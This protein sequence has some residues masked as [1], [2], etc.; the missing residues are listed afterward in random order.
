MAIEVRSMHPDVEKYAYEIRV[1]GPDG[2]LIFSEELGPG[3]SLSQGDIP[4]G[5]I[6]ISAVPF[7]TV[8]SELTS[9][10]PTMSLVVD[11]DNC[12]LGD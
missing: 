3:E 4:L 2:D 12:T 5:W 11:G 8:E 6:T 10:H 9:K 1:V 7:C